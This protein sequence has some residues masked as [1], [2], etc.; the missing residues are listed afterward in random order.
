VKVKSRGIAIFASMAML[1]SL[2]AAGC[3]NDEP[4]A[5]VPPA[6]TT[7]GEGGAVEAEPAQICDEIDV[8]H[9]VDAMPNYAAGVTFHAPSPLT[10]STLYRVHSGYPVMDD[11]RF[12]SYIQEKTNVTFDREDILL[13]DWD[14][15]RSLQV[16]SGQ[17]PTLVPIVWGGQESG[18]W[19]GGNLLPL[20][21][22]TH[23]MPNFEAS[24]AEWGLE[25]EINNQRAGDGNIYR[26][27]L[28]RQSPNIEHSF[29]VNVD[30]FEAAGVDVDSI[31]T[32]DEL[33]EALRAVQ[34]HGDVAYA[35]SDR[36]NEGNSVL[37]ASLQLAS[38]NFD[39]T[40]GWNRSITS[41]DFA[42]DEFVPRVGT[43]G[44]R[45][46]VEWFANLRSEGLLDPE[47]TQTD[48]EAVQKFINGQSAMIASNF[49]EMQNAL[50]SPAAEVGIDLNVKMIRVPDGPAGGNIAGSRVGPGFVV[51]SDIRNSPYFLATLQF[52]DWLYF[53][54]EG[55][56]MQIWGVEGETY[57]VNADGTY[58][59][60]VPS[61]DQAEC[62]A[63]LQQEFGFRDGMWHNWNGPDEL[64]FSM[65]TPEQAAWVQNMA[66]TKTIL[67]P[68][69]AAP[70]T[71]LEQ[72]Q[73][74][75]VESSV[76]DAVD[77][78]VAQFISGTR[79][80]S[81]WDNFVTQIRNLGA[82]QIAELQNAAYQRNQ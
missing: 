58:E 34:A 24:V 11:W 38:P 72:E 20:S 51:N 19:P 40:G 71:E 77:T 79:P 81:D 21:E 22:Y 46:L 28:I 76:Q 70:L 32:F 73:A 63:W 27:P 2:A 44:Y 64:I 31:D 6:V 41:F 45:Q 10:V 74:S 47:I 16:A 26:L 56:V 69:P 25:G 75:L 36:W 67:P 42:N 82:D 49:P 30:K 4:A 13:A 65:M 66:A 50:I 7:P 60:L 35:Y 39:T 78:G 29:A 1:T 59:C 62:T 17:F 48:D 14:N 8:A 33:T 15:S 9:S 54:P 12:W 68:N 57:Q 23:C 80:I 5:T 18:W 53:S 3:G 61:G 43:E 52:L 37:G 55:R